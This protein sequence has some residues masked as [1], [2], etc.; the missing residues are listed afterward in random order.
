MSERTT[1]PK[2][3][4][5]NMRDADLRVKQRRVARE[6]VQ[7][8]GGVA[9]PF[10]A[11]RWASWLHGQMWEQRYK[12][13][14]TRYLD[15]ALVLGV[16]VAEDIAAI[17][18]GAAKAALSALSWADR[19]PFGALCDKLM[20]ELPHVRTPD[21]ATR[22]GQVQVVRAAADRRPGEGEVILFDVRRD[23]DRQAHSLCVYIDETL[24]G[25]AKHLRLLHPFDEVTAGEAAA[26]D[27][28]MSFIPVD[29]G[30][31]C[32][33]VAKAVAATDAAAGATVSDG[34]ADNRAM[35]LAR[36]APYADLGMT[37]TTAA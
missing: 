5:K 33:S 29:L 19:G 21:W 36:I 32:R 7:D 11:E 3:G 12:V 24:G 23:D 22:I 34:Y 18:D 37:A 1:A 4:A 31:A 13:P 10:E 35:A 26:D 30:W 6:M 2:Q 28:T 25:I 8:L 20:S 15:W 17:G 16:T 27:P 9:D 14:E